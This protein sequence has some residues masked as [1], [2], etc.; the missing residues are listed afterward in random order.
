[1][2]LDEQRPQGP[3]RLARLARGPPDLLALAAPLG[4]P[5]LGRPEPVGDAGERLDRPV[6]EVA[7]DAPALL[8]LRVQRA[9]QEP[10][11]LALALAEARRERAGERDLHEPEQR[12]RADER[13]QGLPAE[14]T[15]RGLDPARALVDL[16]EE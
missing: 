7:R 4:H 15:A 13:G 12:E 14:P 10:L 6:V 1:M 11:A 5:A 16:E 8:L 2:D 3:D 9:D